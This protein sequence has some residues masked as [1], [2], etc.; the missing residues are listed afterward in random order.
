MDIE[1]W[2]VVP[3]GI[4]DAGKGRK[5]LIN[6]GDVGG[7]KTGFVPRYPTYR[8]RLSQKQKSGKDA[9]V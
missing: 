4:F 2:C 6:S 9:A 8:V 5:K 1:K 7:Q 3:D